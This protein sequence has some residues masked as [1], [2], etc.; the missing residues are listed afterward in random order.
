MEFGPVTSVA[1]LNPGA[2]DLIRPD[3]GLSTGQGFLVLSV[4]SSLIEELAQHGHI[5]P[6][7]VREC[8]FSSVGHLGL[9]ATSHT[10]GWY[11]MSLWMECLSTRRVVM[12]CSSL[13]HDYR[14]YRM[15]RV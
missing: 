7:L 3:G 4:C 8:R 9:A 10:Q 11:C 12:F 2:H 1:G 15:M 5:A 13:A 14:C 6:G